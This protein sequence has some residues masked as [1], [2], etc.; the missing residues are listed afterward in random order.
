M[1]KKISKLS[2]TRRIFFTMI[3]SV[4]LMIIIVSC[5]EVIQFY[6]N[7]RQEI[8]QLQAKSISKQ[9]G[10]IKSEVERVI[11]YINGLIE[12]NEQLPKDQIT[13]MPE[14][15][16]YIVSQL[17]NIRY[18]TDGYFFASGRNGEP[19]FSNGKITY[20]TGNVWDLT[21]PNGVKII[22]KQ[23]EAFD[24]VIGVYTYYSWQKLNQT[25]LSSKISFTKAVPKLDW[26][27]GTGVY[28]VDINNQV[29]YTKKTLRTTLLYKTFFYFLFLFAY[30]L[31]CWFIIKHFSVKIKKNIESFTTFFLNASENY[32]NIDLNELYYPE[33]K[34]V[35]KAANIMIDK[36]RVIEEALKISEEKYRI[37]IDTTSEGFWMLDA[38]MNTIEVNDSM[39]QMLNFSSNEIF[40]KKPFDFLDSQNFQIFSEYYKKPLKFRHQS[41]ELELNT[42]SGKKLPCLIKSTRLVD[43][44]DQLYASFAFITDITDRKNYEKQLNDYQNH[45]EDLIKERTLDLETK[46]KEL[47]R[48]NKLFVGREFRIKELRD[49]VKALEDKLKHP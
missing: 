44:K 42:K 35:A 22:Q 45:L 17:I 23:H 1:K 21:D 15:K 36:R 5:F 9:K 40:S 26:I 49:Q 30:F 29:A 3:S 12:F 41:F 10:M 13:A 20:G 47:K 37:L 39:C 34:K 24:S 38:E 11:F 31:L 6:R 16:N 18:R 27:I 14:L 32:Q 19:L 48:Y 33:F 43:D 4:T 28:L 8:E 2:L 46:N 7:Y 25:V